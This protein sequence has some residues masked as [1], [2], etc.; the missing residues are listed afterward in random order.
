MF[1]MLKVAVSDCTLLYG[2]TLNQGA[3][4]GC[5]GVSYFYEFCRLLSSSNLYFGLWGHIETGCGY[6]VYGAISLHPPLDC[7]VL[8]NERMM[9]MPLL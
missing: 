9:N 8:A 3:P 7:D 1:R 2:V 4:T 5:N 6:G